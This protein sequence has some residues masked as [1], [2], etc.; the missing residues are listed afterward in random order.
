MCLR[1]PPPG[2]VY[3]FKPFACSQVAL[4]TA[5]GSKYDWSA[6]A[7]PRAKR[8]QNNTRHMQQRR[9]V[10]LSQQFPRMTSCVDALKRFARPQHL[11][12]AELFNSLWLRLG[13]KET[14]ET[15]KSKCSAFDISRV[16]QPPEGNSQ[17]WSVP[18]CAA[19]L[20]SLDDTE[21][22]QWSLLAAIGRYWP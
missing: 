21:V 18:P 9:Q 4:Q 20:H 11:V 2:F 19:H 3:R 22:K 17:P 8:L 15:L 13:S 7:A 5:E 16:L 1:S 12:V 14:E 10:K 6:M